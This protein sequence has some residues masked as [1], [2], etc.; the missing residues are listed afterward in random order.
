MSS[1][2]STMLKEAVGVFSILI[3]MATGILASGGSHHWAYSGEDD[4]SHWYNFYDLCSGNKQSPIDIVPSTAKPQ[5]FLPIHLGNYDTIGKSFTLINNGHTVLL[6][7]PKNYADYRMPFVR[8]GGLTNQFIFAQLHFHWGA[9]GDRGSEHTVNNKHYAA[10][11][12]FVHFNKKYGSLGNATSHP[13]GLAVLGV[14]VETSKEDNPAF[15]PITSV[16]DHVVHEGHEWE[17]NETLSLRDLLPESLS[18]FYR[19]MG[20][21]TTPGCQEIVVWTVFADPITASESQLAEFRQLLGEDGEILVN[22]YR[23]AQPLMG[24][25]VHVRSSSTKMIASLVAFLLPIVAVL[26]L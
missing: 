11:L 6:S 15:D 22:N 16:L 4:P 18:K 21:L 2:H 26:A 5:N 20:S 24:R 8:D 12:H 19:Y 14:F 3:L 10:E 25:T 17:L 1:R 23:P 13:D 7:L 9:E